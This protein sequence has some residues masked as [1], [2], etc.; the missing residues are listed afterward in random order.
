MTH[1]NLY[2]MAISHYCEKVRWALDFKGVAYTA[3]TLLPGPHGKKIQQ[4]TQS[5][6]TAVPVLE[7]EG[8][9]LQN[10]SAI[11][12]Y[13]ETSFPEPALDSKPDADKAKA[14]EKFADE[15]IGP[16]VRMCCYHILLERRDLLVPMLAQG[17]PWYG[18]IFLT[19]IF[20]KLVQLMRQS[21]KIDQAGFEMS[22][23]CLDGAMARI[24]AHLRD[25]QFLVGDSFSRADLAVASLLAPLSRA[26]G[27]G[28]EWP[29]TLPLELADME[30]KYQPVLSWVNNIYESFRKIET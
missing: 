29:S 10:S 22:R 3:H 5:K 12:D 11:L 23:Q 26:R 25:R 17:G 18:R 24:Q 9:I 13:L 20:P 27:Y 14:W 16:H 28:I 8:K 30:K 6:Q 7:H 19:I 21:M 15:E 4:L 1:V 2:Q